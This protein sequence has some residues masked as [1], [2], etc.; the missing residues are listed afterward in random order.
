MALIPLLEI[1]FRFK[2]E[3]TACEP[4]FLCDDII[5]SSTYRL[6]FDI[7]NRTEETEIILC[8]SCYNA[9]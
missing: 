7:A 4:C 3:Q 6:V 1:S 9:V 5:Y 2:E 8:Q